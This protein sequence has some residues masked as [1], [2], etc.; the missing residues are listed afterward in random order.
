MSGTTPG[1]N[2]IRYSPRRVVGLGTVR[3]EWVAKLYAILSDRWQIESLPSPE[4]LRALVLHA[5][6]Q[7]DAPLDH[8]CGFAIFHM[9]DD[10]IYLLVTRFNN[11]NNLRHQVYAVT[12][13]EGKHRLNALAD[14]HI[15][16]CVW[17]LR[18][19]QFE[20]DAWT[21]C[22]LKAGLSADSVRRYLHTRYQGEV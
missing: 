6:D 12:V 8:G 11:A 7:L 18:L 1:P 19:M 22:V 13:G 21:K 9:A 3:G 2:P 10:G 15:I 16:A 14:Q 20:A 4:A 5:M 17:E